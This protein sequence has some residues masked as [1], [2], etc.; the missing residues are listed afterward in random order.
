MKVQ[1]VNVEVTTVCQAKCSLCIRNKYPGKVEIPK[2][3]LDLD[4]F[5]SL[6]W[7]NAD[8]EKVLLCGSFGD[9][10][11]HP[12]LFRLIDIIHSIGAR[13]VMFTNGEPHTQK[14]WS[15]FAII[16]NDDDEVF[17]GIDGLDSE[18][19]VKYRG[20][21]FDKV[22]KNINTFISSGG[23]AN[24]QF[25]V[26]RHNQHQIPE[27]EEFS[28]SLKLNYAHI[29]G[30]REYSDLL[31]KPTKPGKLK[32]AGCFIDS[33]EAGMGIDAKLYICCH[34]SIRNFVKSLYPERIN[35]IIK[36]YNTFKEFKEN[37]YWAFNRSKRPNIWDKITENLC[38]D[39]THK[40]W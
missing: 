18:T 32:N 12:N 33:G 1:S 13:F 25:I 39:C 24:M 21:S 14:W 17:F 22:I 37:I 19:H 27:I 11:F 31:E 10:I 9:P 6:D 40:N 28:K 3:Y 35:G 30:S 7:Q 4:K 15:K 2:L 16:C 8:V 26:F 34:S 29:I 38:D 23:T 20:T 5:E 36:P